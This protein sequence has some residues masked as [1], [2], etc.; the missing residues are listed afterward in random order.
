MDNNKAYLFIEH[1]AMLQGEP[2][3]N[4]WRVTCAY[5]DG[6]HC[7]IDV[8]DDEGRVDE[9]YTRVNIRFAVLNMAEDLDAAG[10]RLLDFVMEIASGKQTKSEERGIREISIFKDG[11]VL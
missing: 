10:D 2:L 9:D 7:D 3:E 1:P 11:V 8:L 6:T 5:L 4:G